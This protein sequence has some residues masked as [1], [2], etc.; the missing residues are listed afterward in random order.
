MNMI[1]VGIDLDKNV[2]AIH[3]VDDNGKPVLVKPKVARADLQTRPTTMGTT[4]DG[5]DLRPGY[6]AA[7]CHRRTVLS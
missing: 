7:V 2:F 4:G 6:L 1:I 3:G 5:I